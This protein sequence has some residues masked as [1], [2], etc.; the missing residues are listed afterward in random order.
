M[1]DGNIVHSFFFVVLV[2]VGL[3]MV[4]LVAESLHPQH[5]Q[6]AMHRKNHIILHLYPEDLDENIASDMANRS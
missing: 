4:F 3:L 1:W 5:D 6:I 2:W